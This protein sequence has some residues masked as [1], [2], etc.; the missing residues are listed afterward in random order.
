VDARTEQMILSKLKQQATSI[1]I[2]HRLA[3]ISFASQIL[4]LKNGR[5]EACGPHEQLLS[6][7]PT[8]SK[9]YEIQK[10]AALP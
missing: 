8:Y 5:V 3:S 9:L 10:E 2:S 4:V 6:Q 1:V 7:S